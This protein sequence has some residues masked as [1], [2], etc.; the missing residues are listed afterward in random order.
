M[1]AEVIGYQRTQCA[2]CL[3]GAGSEVAQHV[4]AS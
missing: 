1:I 3:T 4:G 2:S